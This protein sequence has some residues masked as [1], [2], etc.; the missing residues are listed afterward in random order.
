MVGDKSVR[1][2]LRSFTISHLVLAYLEAVDVVRGGREVLDAGFSVEV[3]VLVFDDVHYVGV[4]VS[5][6]AFGIDEFV[7]L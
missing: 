3:L 1:K 4:D 5:V 6:V 7:I 2:A